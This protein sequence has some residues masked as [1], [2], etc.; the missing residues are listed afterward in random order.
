MERTFVMVKPNGVRRNL[1]GEIIRR[2]ERTGLKIIAM[3]M[4]LISPELA[5]KHYQEHVEKD[6]YPDLETFITSGPVVAMILEGEEA[7][8]VAR[9]LNGA[10]DPVMAVP[11]SIRGDLG[12]KKTENIVH[13]SDSKESAAREINLFFEKEEIMV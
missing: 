3:K 10:T 4:I 7:I 6:F 13:G 8:E 5:K 9:K 12:R 1:T 2:Y 11:G